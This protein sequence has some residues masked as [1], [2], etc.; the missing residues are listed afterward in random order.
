MYYP[1]IILCTA[2]AGENMPCHKGHSTT[3]NVN[4]VVANFGLIYVYIFMNIDNLS[5]WCF[6]TNPLISLVILLIFSIRN[7]RYFELEQANFVYVKHPSSGSLGLTPIDDPWLRVQLE[8]LE[9]DELL[10]SGKDSS[11]RL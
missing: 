5:E 8:E 2:F 6:G 7:N 9:A 1:R 10:S 11:S 4:N 3:S